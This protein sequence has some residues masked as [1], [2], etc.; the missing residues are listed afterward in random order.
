MLSI[1]L[2]CLALVFVILGIYRWYYIKV[3]RYEYFG[4][5][6][7][8]WKSGRQL[9]EEME[10]LKKGRIDPG[11]FYESMMHLQDEELIELQIRNE[12]FFGTRSRRSYYRL[13]SQGMRWIEER[14]KG[15]HESPPVSVMPNRHMVVNST[16]PSYLHSLTTALSG[17]VLDEKFFTFCFV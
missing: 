13:T 11:S 5:L 7:F 15:V 17:F 3:D 16:K 1:C 14:D 10:K 6:T 2:I 4:V 9:R 12:I 8:N